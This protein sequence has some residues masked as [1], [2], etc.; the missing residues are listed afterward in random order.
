MFL[1]A[2]FCRFF[3][4][5]EVDWEGGLGGRLGVLVKNLRTTRVLYWVNVSDSSGAGS[6]G[7][8]D[9]GSLSDCCC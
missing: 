5:L 1:R 6:P 4:V 2:V 3:S 8:P 9:D 7:C